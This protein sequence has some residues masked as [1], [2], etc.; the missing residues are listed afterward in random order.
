MEA[1]DVI[2]AKAGIQSFQ[3]FLDPGFHRCDVECIRIS[4]KL[5]ALGSTKLGIIFQRPVAIHPFFD[6]VCIEI[7]EE[8]PR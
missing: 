8:V 4:L 3:S 6:K 7:V 1:P 5:M 2:P